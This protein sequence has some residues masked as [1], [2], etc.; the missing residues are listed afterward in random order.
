MW[1]PHS[2]PILTACSESCVPP[3]VNGPRDDFVTG[4]RLDVIYSYRNSTKLHEAA[5]Q[6]LCTLSQMWIYITPS[7]E[8]SASRCVTCISLTSQSCW[9]SSAERITDC[10]AWL[11]RTTYSK[12][13]EEAEHCNTRLL[14]WRLR[15]FWSQWHESKLDHEMIFF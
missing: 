3:G 6:T 13:H 8:I 12:P 4:I 10:D 11:L 7:V 15:S 14:H 1:T 2:I 5:I 9:S